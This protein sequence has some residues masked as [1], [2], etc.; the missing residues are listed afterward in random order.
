MDC[1][2]AALRRCLMHQVA[3][4][5]GRMSPEGRMVSRA[6]QQWV[7]RCEESKDK[8][9]KGNRALTMMSPEGR[10]KGRSFRAW[11]AWALHRKEQMLKVQQ[12]MKR[13][14][15]EGRA[16]YSGMQGFKARTPAWLEG[17]DRVVS[18]DGFWVVSTLHKERESVLASPLIKR[19]LFRFSFRING[20]GAGLVVGVADASVVDKFGQ[21]VSQ[22][23]E[24]LKAWGLHLTHGALYTKKPG[25]TKGVLSSKQLVP[26]QGPETPEEDPDNAGVAFIEQIIDIEVEVDMDRR[27]IA[28]GL[29][30]GPLV[31]AP[32]KLTSCVRPWAYLWNSSD[33]V[34]IGS[35]PIPSRNAKQARSLLE[36]AP[37]TAAAPVP[38]R[39]RSSR[40]LYAS[41]PGGGG[42]DVTA[43]DGTPLLLRL[44]SHAERGDYLPSYA[45]NDRSFYE[46]RALRSP[47]K[48]AFTSARN[49]VLATKRALT[50]ARSPS[51]DKAAG[52]SEEVG[53]GA[54]PAR[55]NDDSGWFSTPPSKKSGRQPDTPGTGL[56]TSRLAVSLSTARNRSPRSPRSPRGRGVTH[57]WDVVR[58]VTGVYGEVYK[59]I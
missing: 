13:M 37:A 30:G 36:R 58:Y 43:R 7:A 3:S 35:R 9:A 15:P 6:L 26:S 57:M 12:F 21:P 33:S 46:A 8:R 28:F 56:S 29:P 52:M 2:P 41:V 27:R 10:A 50:S 48:S 14:S 44:P 45:Y 59:Q 51:G 49:A 47:A 32:V 39:A 23:V 17:V 25:T 18:D 24:E 5:L 54:T 20:T 40:D 4:A 16:M 31:E 22:S 11:F 34:M 42:F 1:L 38:L 53:S 19:G 55:E